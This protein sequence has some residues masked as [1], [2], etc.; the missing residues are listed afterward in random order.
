MTNPTPIDLETYAAAVLREAVR[1]LGRRRPAMDVDDIA[2]EVVEQF[3]ARPGEVMA[4]YPDPAHFAR[5]A[6]RRRSIAWDRQQRGQRG[7][8][9]RLVEAPDGTLAPRRTVISG[10]APGESGG[11]VFGGVA[12]ERPAVEDVA[13]GAVDEAVL[14]E[15]CLA[16][17]SR[18]DREVL[19]LVDGYGFTVKEV[20]DRLGVRR[21]TVSRRLSRTRRQAE[22]SAAVFAPS[23]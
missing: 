1:L 7:A 11:E 23:G 4:R 9:V 16:G 20:A 17:M 5:A 12:D 22:R 19:M 8:G 13:V 10:N 14:L 2:A 15:Q 18:T 6:A 3:L 21:E